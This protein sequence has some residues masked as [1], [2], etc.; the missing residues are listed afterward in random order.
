V[1]RVLLGILTPS[2]NTRLEPLTV[3]MLEG[4]P[5]VTAHFSRFR[6]VDVGLE[7]S[8]QFDLDP[9]LAAADLLADARVDAI[10]WSGTS[11]GWRGIEHD[12]RLCA[13]IRQRTGV[14]ATTST[15]A[16]MEAVTGNGDRAV[17]LVTPYPDDLHDVVVSTL[18]TAGV[19]ITGSRNHFV[20]K[21]NW[22]LSTIPAEAVGAMVAELVA[23]GSDAIAVYCTNLA[24][25]Q[26]AAAWEAEYGVPVYDSVALAVWGALRLAGV[27]PGRVAGWGSLFAPQKPHIDKPGTDN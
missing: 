2:S 21:S 8:A 4:L 13:L 17:G 19:A 6:V 7:A 12:T 9:I 3:S 20:T 23:D 27:D 25:A 18:T 16:L 22:E 14:P 1:N 5:E 10:A 24:A 11:G 15:L 26:E